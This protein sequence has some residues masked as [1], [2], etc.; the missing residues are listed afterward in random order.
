MDAVQLRQPL[1]AETPALLALAQS[2]GLFADG[3]VDDL[4]GTTLAAFHAGELGSDHAIR[5][6]SLPSGELL[7]WLYVAPTESP[8][9]PELLWVG[10]QPS[11]H[12]AGA[13]SLLLAEAERL[14]R[15]AGGS[16]L[17]VSTSSLPA[18]APAR[19]LYERRGFTQV[20]VVPDYYGPGD[21]AVRY[22]KQLVGSTHQAEA[23]AVPVTYSPRA[24]E[25]AHW[26]RAGHLTPSQAAALKEFMQLC[27]AECSEDDALRW[28]R[29][30]SF[31]LPKALALRSSCLEWWSTV[32]PTLVATRHNVRRFTMER[33]LVAWM[34]A[35]CTCGRGVVAVDC[36]QHVPAEGRAALPVFFLYLDAAIAQSPPGDLTVVFDVRAFGRG[37]MDTR[38]A[39]AMV[40][41]LNAGYPERLG[42]AY[43]LGA[44]RVFI[45]L[46]NVVRVALDARTRSKVCFL[47]SPEALAEALGV[48]ALPQWMGGTPGSRLDAHLQAF[49]D[50]AHKH[51]SD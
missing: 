7:G 28:L 30:R 50:G 5:V 19:A 17:R 47:R 41:A 6:A 11:R 8:T 32:R 31:H 16:V 18:T 46:W 13:G 14:A 15:A 37:N 29:A 45:A 12:R 25:V 51:M 35:L 1:P 27:K 24:S 33:R 39:L 42:C 38:T 36:S 10:V 26:G 48:D 4:L 2:T 44:P 20:E 23:V 34:P 9:E 49:L 21:D 43:I 22:T 3:E 40:K